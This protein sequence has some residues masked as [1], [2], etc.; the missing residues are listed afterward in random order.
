MSAPIVPAENDDDCDAPTFTS[1][2]ETAL[3]GIASIVDS[4]E[5][6]EKNEESEQVETEIPTDNIQKYL[7]LIR[8]ITGR[9][10]GH[11]SFVSSVSF[12]PDGRRIV[13]GG[14]RTIRIWDAESGQELLKLE[15]HSSSV[16]SVSFSPDGRRIVS[17]SY[18]NTIRIWDA[19]SGQELLK[20]E[21]HSGSVPSVSFSPDGRRIVSGSGDRTI[22]IW[23]DIFGRLNERLKDEEYECLCSLPYKLNVFRYVC[24]FEECVAVHF[25]NTR[26]QETFLADVFLEDFLKDRIQ[27]EDVTSI[28]NL[29][30]GLDAVNQ[31]EKHIRL[32]GVLQTLE[33]PNPRNLERFASDPTVIKWMNIVLGNNFCKFM[34]TWDFILQIL[35]L[36]SFA[37]VAYYFQDIPGTYQDIVYSDDEELI[38]VLWTLLVVNCYYTIYEMRQGYAMYHLKLFLSWVNN[39]WNIADF[40]CLATSYLLV[41]YS[42]FEDM[43]MSNEFRIIGSVGVMLLWFRM[44]GFIKGTNAKLATFV[45]ALFQIF[46]DLGAFMVVLVML[47]ATFLHGIFI[48]AHRKGIGSEIESFASIKNLA[49]SLVGMVLGE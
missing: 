39:I 47:L 33:Q 7:P 42:W 13:S 14:D 5:L 10:L 18:D 44:L 9:Q 21:G 48:Y 32:L 36:I 43:R 37:Y 25:R 40:G 49:L 38:L 15:G 22:R 17:G 28:L 19:E 27:N 16:Y 41:I 35:H 29:V 1:E 45:L 12:S 2:K 8:A 4:I 11:S 24:Y 31:L 26:F 3:K 6:P 30:H 34:M 23:D 46:E 20:L